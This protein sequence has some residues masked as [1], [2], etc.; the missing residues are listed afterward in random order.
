MVAIERCSELFDIESE[1]PDESSSG[2]G[3][4]AGGVAAPG[5]NT[6]GSK[7]AQIAPRTSSSSSV[8]SSSVVSSSS[9][10]GAK[11]VTPDASW[12]SKGEVEFRQ[13]VVRYRPK[14]PTVLKGVSLTVAAGTKVG[15]CGRTGSGK[16]TLALTVFR[17]IEAEEG[18]IWIDGVDI[19]TL[20]LE[21]LRS[22]ITMIP[23][24]PVLFAG[25]LRYSLDPVGAYS[26]TA[27]WDAID[28]VNLRSF[29]EGME[30]GLD[31]QVADGGE[32]LSAGQRQLLC[33]ARA[34]LEK[35]KILLM[36]EATSN[37]SGREDDKIQEMLR[38]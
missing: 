7:A 10:A 3:A 1:E 22:R 38:R 23:Q 14:L 12:P 26:D 5:G 18:T 9:S 27:I 33:V 29:V 34:V 4:K 36:D 13:L 19:A 16:S 15:I 35:P 20:R 24:D 11:L 8:V 21:E 17:I 28:A 31:S 2:R 32:N 30:S 25:P 37:I 6:T